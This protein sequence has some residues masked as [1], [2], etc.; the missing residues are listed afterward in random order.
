MTLGYID[1]EFDLPGALFAR[2]IDALERMDPAIMSDENISRVP[3][4]PGVYLLLLD[5]EP[6]Y[7]GKTDSHS[8][9]AGRL[10]RHRDK[11]RHR[12]DLD[13]SRV[14]FKAVRIY[15]FT[16]MDLESQ[17][18][19][20]YGETVAWNNSGFGSNDPG[21]ERDTSRY[22]EK[23]YDRRFPIDID[24]RLEIEVQGIDSTAN[25][26]ATLKKSLPYVFR[27]QTAK[28]RSIH[29]HPDL[30]NTAIAIPANTIPTT[31]RLIELGVAQ[32]PPGWKATKLPS[33]LILYKFDAR[34]FPFG[35]EIAVSG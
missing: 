24:R 8:G 25:L 34:E 32:L 2:L 6:V 15:V 11:I 1:F 17:L 13:R 18:L 28:P 21:R 9:L 26:F 3:E 10:A 16:A 7:V 29:P 4:V 20:H 33:H 35:E 14:S 12:V 19:D 27:F 22:S 30:A 23:H 31:R 5:G